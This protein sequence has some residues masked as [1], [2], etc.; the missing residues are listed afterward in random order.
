MISERVIFNQSCSVYLLIDGQC[1]SD[2]DM[3]KILDDFW[4]IFL[5]SIYASL[6]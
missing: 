5:L 1:Q 4:F 3:N 2:F 6:P